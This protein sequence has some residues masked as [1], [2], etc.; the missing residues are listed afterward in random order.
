MRRLALLLALALAACSG[1]G[2]P[3]PAGDVTLQVLSNRA[4]LVSDGNAYMEV[5]VPPGSMADDL[6][7]DVDG[8]DVTS[9]FARRPNGRILGVV[10]GL[11]VGA[12]TVTARLAGVNKGARLVVTNTARG[13]PIFSGPQLQPW[14]CATKAGSAVHVTVPGT[15]L[16]AS[17][18]TAV[19]GLDSDPV[20]A[21]C[22]TPTKYDHYYKPASKA[23][24]CTVGIT[25]TDPCFVPYDPAARPADALIADFTNDRGDRVKALVRLESGVIDRGSYV[26]LS[27]FDPAQASSPWSPQKGWNGKLLYRFGAAASGNRFQYRA[28]LGGLAGPDWIWDHNALA[29]GFMVAAGSLTNHLDNNN[30]VLAA[31]QMMMI[32]EHIIDTYGEIRYTMGEGASGGSM[33]QTGIASVM[34]GLLQ[35]LLTGVSYPD[36]I[37]TWIETRD[38]ALA[39]EFYKT[40][41]GSA[42]TADQRTAI[43]GH[44]STHC[45]TWVASFLLSQKPTVATNCAGLG[46]LIPNGLAFPAS[47]VYDP[48]LR[49]QGVRCSIHD[50]MGNIFG[51]V[52]ESGRVVP[53]LPYDNVGVQYGLKA[54]ASGAITPEQFVRLNEAIGAY[55]TDL[56]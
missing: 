41:A 8:T 13:G 23:P 46:A 40:S 42:F 22:N 54:L 49:P 48:V 4:D 28:E 24:T 7:V 12:N 36:A 2:D 47:L 45:P 37:S 27:Y 34:P 26:I 33:M 25:G 6:K 53:K 15:S 20:D 19:N 50:V 43:E 16:A 14:I 9:A 1:G 39:A 52:M 51:T 30:E 3:G 55:D 5:V 10:T 32:K 44:P 31:E 17:V 35:G 56:N 38:C 21:Q 18:P 11:K 29:R